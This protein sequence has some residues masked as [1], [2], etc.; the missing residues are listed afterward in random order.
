MKRYTSGYFSTLAPTVIG[1]HIIVGTGGDTSDIPCWLESRD[2]ETGERQ[3]IWY[4][5]PHKG[6]PGIETWPSEAASL[7]GGGGPWQPPTYDPDL[8]LLYIT[9]ANPNPVYNGLSRKGDNLYT[10]S[11]VALNPDTGKM[12]W[13]YQFS[14][15]DTHDWDATQ[16]TPLIDGVFNGQPRKMLAQAN[17]G[18]WYFL[19]DRTNGKSLV[20]KP[21]LTNANA[22]K[23]AD[24]QGRMVPDTDKEPSLGGTLVSPS[25]DGASNYPAQSFSPDTGL[26]YVNSIESYSIYYLTASDG[27]AI[28][29]GGSQES[30]TGLFTAYLRALDIKPA[31]SSG[32]T[33]MTATDSDPAPIQ[34]Y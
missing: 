17:R 24:A 3:W 11:V 34:E 27:K 28:G 16:V 26:F 25:S 10:C 14:P 31:P 5:T 19:L 13:Y 6:E 32:S 15:H 33:S 22:Y 20:V 2:P 1:R 7:H 4:A 18:G 29:T 21:F 23:G 30:H 8:N 9:T 12:S